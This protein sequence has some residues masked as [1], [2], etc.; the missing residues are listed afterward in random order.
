MTY[1][2]NGVPLDNPQFGWGLQASSDVLSAITRNAA[3]LR[4]FGRDGVASLPAFADAVPLTFV[5]QTPREHVEALYALFNADVLEVS[6][7]VVP[8][9]VLE[10]ELLSLSP[11]GFG[12]N[13]E[14]GRYR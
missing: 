6:S 11:S 10:T 1:S 5:V 3:T 12:A 2:I 9:R 13:H 14:I 7:D 4:P 8:G